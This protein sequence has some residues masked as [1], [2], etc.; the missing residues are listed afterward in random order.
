[1]FAVRF[2]VCSKVSPNPPLSPLL[3]SFTFHWA[4][5]SPLC[6]SSLTIPGCCPFK[7]FQVQGT[8]AGELIKDAGLK[9]QLQPHYGSSTEN[10]K[11]AMIF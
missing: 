8:S 9:M 5:A 2:A 4:V 10:T 3:S 11:C 1:M 6:L 7:L